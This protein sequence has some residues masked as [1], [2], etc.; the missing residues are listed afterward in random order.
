M[1][2][3]PAQAGGGEIAVRVTPRASRE[4]IEPDGAGYRVYVTVPPEGGKANDAAREVLARHL[5]VAKTRLDLVRGAKSRNK[6]FR[7]TPD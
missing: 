7:L 4:R 1:T 5:G 3:N 6:V 2:E